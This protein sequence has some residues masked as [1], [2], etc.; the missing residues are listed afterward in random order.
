MAFLIAILI[1]IS[2]LVAVAAAIGLGTAAV[3]RARRAALLWLLAIITSRRLP[4]AAEL[5]AMGDGMLRADRGAANAIAARVRSGASLGEALSAGRGLVS[6]DIVLLARVGE[7]A[8]CLGDAFG[9]EADR[10]ARAREQMVS[11]TTSPTLA[12]VYLVAIPLIIPVIV[13]GLM[14]FIVPKMERIFSEFN[15]ELPWAS[16]KLIESSDLLGN[17]WY[18]AV[19][20]LMALLSFGGVF[21]VLMKVYAWDLHVPRWLMPGGRSRRSSLALRALVLPVLTGR[22]LI[23][24]FLPLANSLDASDRWKFSRI[25]DQYESGGDLWQLLS[26]EGIIS[27]REGQLLAA[28]EKAGNLAWALDLLADR[29]DERRLRWFA[30][31]LEVVQPAMVLGLG[32]LVLFICLGIFHPL[33]ELISV[34]G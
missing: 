2:Q 5:E 16:K 28:A 22:P 21:M 9:R 12:M 33:V 15:V 19:A 3:T 26:R 31:L 17:Y 32:A 24:A 10:L 25:K 29:I 7:R 1:A 23:D 18:V 30:M 27:N 20:S 13:T 6:N 8:G 34:L 14:I 4:L 11:S